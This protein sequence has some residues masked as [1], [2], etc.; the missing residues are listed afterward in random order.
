VCACVDAV[1]VFEGNDRGGMTEREWPSASVWH[2]SCV[3]EGM[4]DG[5]WPRRECDVAAMLCGRR[6]R[7]GRGGVVVWHGEVGA[8]LGIAA[9]GR[10]R[11]GPGF[12]GPWLGRAV[13]G[14]PASWARDKKRR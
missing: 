5:A 1:R 12:P 11:A 13:C 14:A 9:R 8:R 7:Q 3:F 6:A 4:T 10:T 2:A